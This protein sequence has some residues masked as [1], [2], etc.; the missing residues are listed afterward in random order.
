[1][2]IDWI[3]AYSIL[4]SSLKSAMGSNIPQEP[5]Y[6][7]FNT[8]VSSTWGFP[9]DPPPECVR[10]YD[11]HNPNCACAMPV[12]FCEMLNKN[13]TDFLINYVRVYQSPDPEAH[14]GQNHTIGCD[15]VAF[16]SKEYIEGNEYLYMRPAPWCINDKHPLKPIAHGGGKCKSDS[17]CGGVKYGACIAANS[18]SGLFSTSGSGTECKCQHGYTGPYCLSVN[19]FDDYPGA[20]EMKGNERLFHQ[21]STFYLPQAVLNIGFFLCVFFA[22]ALIFQVRNRKL[23]GGAYTGTVPATP[24]SMR[25]P[26]FIASGQALND[27]ERKRLLIITGTSV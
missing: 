7:L 4:D 16:P 19:K 6:V 25:R 15:P 12:G 13:D 20:L 8:A 17:D 11:C 18:G 5:S 3:K 21:I 1:M 9:Y 24:R 2:G 14:V 10:C 23:T 27:D 26:Q 22:A